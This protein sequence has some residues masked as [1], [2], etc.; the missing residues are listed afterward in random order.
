MADDNKCGH[1][2]CGC[3]VGD[4]QTYCSDHCE[5]AADQDIIEISCDCGHAECV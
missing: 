5:T 3:P 1:Q 2:A 4:D